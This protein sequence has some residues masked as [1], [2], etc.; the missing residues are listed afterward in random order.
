MMVSLAV[1]AICVQTVSAET[2]A[3]TGTSGGDAPGR[4]QVADSSLT[5]P[6]RIPG[7]GTV[8]ED[9]LIV[10]AD[11]SLFEITGPTTIT[12]PGTYRLMQDILDSDADSFCILIT[13]SDVIFD[14]MG[15]TIRGLHGSNTH[16]IHAGWT[17]ANVTVR[18]VTVEGWG[19]AG[20]DGSGIRFNGVQDGLIEKITCRGNY[21][22][23]II[24]T[25][26]TSGVTVRDCDVTD[27]GLG[28]SLTDNAQGNQVVRNRVFGILGGIGA[29]TAHGNTIADNEMTDGEFQLADGS[30]DNIVR[31]NH[32]NNV[33]FRLTPERHAVELWN[34]ATNNLIYD[35]VFNGNA[36]GKGND[37]LQIWN[38]TPRPGTNVLGG[39][40][41][42][43]NAWL[44]PDGWGFSQ[45][46]PDENGDGFCDE[47][48]DDFGP[49]G[50]DYHPLYVEAEDQIPLAA[51]FTWSPADPIAGEPV[52]FIDTSTG[53][54][55]VIYWEFSHLDNHLHQ[56]PTGNLVYTFPL[57]GDFNV[58]VT[59]VDMDGNPDFGWQLGQKT[60]HVRPNSAVAKPTADLAW[61]PA[62]PVTGEPVIFTDRSSADTVYRLWTV[63]GRTFTGQN[64]TELVVN[65]TTPGKKTVTLAAS[66]AGGTT[67]VSKDVTI[68]GAMIEM[69]LVVPP[70]LTLEAGETVQVPVVLSVLPMGVGGGTFNV[71]IEDPTVAEITDLLFPLEVEYPYLYTPPPGPSVVWWASR[72]D[73]RYL[74]N[75]P[76]GTVTVR[77]IANGTTAVHYEVIDVLD[78]YWTPYPPITAAG[79]TLTIGAVGAP[80]AA[81]FTANATSGLAPLTVRFTDTSTGTPARWSWDFG[82]GETSSVQ[83]PVHTYDSVGTYTVSLN[84][85]SAAGATTK[86]KTGYITTGR[87]IV[88]LPA[89]A[90][91]P[92]DLNDDGLYEDLNGNGRTDFNDVVLYFNQMG[93]IMQHEPVGSFDCNR[94]GRIDFAD[95]VLL[96][97][98]L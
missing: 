48:A 16:G 21:P 78:K 65:F 35:N 92:V 6:Q 50:I 96:F 70:V 81:N 27:G 86:T 71:S 53:T 44:R 40:M 90:K 25:G 23:N 7:G 24:L 62:N 69:A 1:L 91:P 49:R 29:Y 80:P 61:S 67:T 51:N 79:S 64:V 17:I 85:S 84:A 39:S 38:V 77:G 82:D 2:S 14:G 12:S 46:H 76:F 57:A 66:N 30:H 20:A 28:I 63:D 13:S 88:P 93:F 8:D 55:H 89:T 45:T 15:H 43:G 97:N 54:V 34:G 98:N 36:G 9:P 26:G 11:P 19:N 37:P 22:Y 5:L 32:Q 4:V 59:A 52:E 74:T 31:G 42:G 68:G 87:V 56:P 60:V 41:I 73:G 72:P 33:N 18:N 83:N 3:F 47:P 94:N 95:V 10:E 75:V 58:S